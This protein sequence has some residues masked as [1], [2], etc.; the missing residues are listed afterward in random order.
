MTIVGREPELSAL[1]TVLDAVQAGAPRASCAGSAT[2]CSAAGAG[3]AS[4]SAA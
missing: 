2:A 4:R 1:A 3:P